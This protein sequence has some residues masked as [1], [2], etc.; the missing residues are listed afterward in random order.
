MSSY[1]KTKKL[2][3]NYRKNFREK[4]LGKDS[5]ELD[6]PEDYGPLQPL[7]DLWSDFAG[8][9]DAERY[10][11]GL[12]VPGYPHT[13]PG[14]TISE[15]EPENPI[16]KASWKHDQRYKDSSYYLAPSEADD[17]WISDVKE[18]SDIK[19]QIVG[20]LGSAVFGTKAAFSTKDKKYY[21]EEELNDTMAPGGKRQKKVTDDFVKKRGNYNDQQKPKP[22]VEIGEPS[23]ST[24]AVEP[25]QSTPAIQ[26][27]ENMSGLDGSNNET[28]LPGHGDS[29]SGHLTK[30]WR[31]GN[32]IKVRTRYTYKVY[33][34]NVFPKQ[35]VAEPYGAKRAI[36]G[37]GSAQAYTGLDVEL[38]WRMLP[39]TNFANYFKY[40]DLMYGLQANSESVRLDACHIKISGLYSLYDYMTSTADLQ[41]Q[42]ASPSYIRI[43]IPK[44]T[45]KNAQVS[46]S[47]TGTNNQ[48]TDPSLPYANNDLEF[49]TGDCH[50][51]EKYKWTTNGQ[52]ITHNSLKPYIHTIDTAGDVAPGD[53]N[54]S[55]AISWAKDN[56][57]LWYPDLDMQED[58]ELL[59]NGE[60]WQWNWKNSDKDFYN[61]RSFPNTVTGNA[62]ER[63]FPE[64][65]IGV[66]SYLFSK[67]RTNVLY[68]SEVLYADP[69]TPIDKM[70]DRGQPY[71]TDI[72]PIL[73]NVPDFP[74]NTGGSP[75]TNH[76]VH[77]NYFYATYSGVLCF[78]VHNP[79]PTY[80]LYHYDKIFN[81]PYDSWNQKPGLLSVTNGYEIDKYRQIYYKNRDKYMNRTNKPTPQDWDNQNSAVLPFAAEAE[82]ETEGKPVKKK[83]KF[84]NN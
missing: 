28:A 51:T 12:T 34:D 9:T 19:D 5:P 67:Q 43:C 64:A 39:T 32:V 21:T 60:D 57:Q 62:H 4:Y 54:A 55:V 72:R 50:S 14:N 29:I 79:N 76:I 53:T 16:D 75:S 30:V 63:L 24:S 18:G 2:R 31:E 48:L 52:S 58:I 40:S 69:G 33:T 68:N 3:E 35:Y 66:F 23:A 17:D 41:L 49:Q 38:P 13:G 26:N 83:K 56:P 80:N 10:R 70:M 44:H 15:T 22:D 59:A 77:K 8:H 61:L 45:L 27:K 20:K 11:G 78:K 71:Q 6:Q 81:R 1:G 25:V 74:Q 82:E 42:N 37:Q 65:D 36:V 73:I 84:G 7:Y 47:L 46:T